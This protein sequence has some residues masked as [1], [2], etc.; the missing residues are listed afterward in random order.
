MGN[1]FMT[2][3]EFFGGADNGK[4]NS[5]RAPRKRG[6][7]AEEDLFASV[8]TKMV[9]R[10]FGVSRARALEIIA[11]KDGEQAAAETDEAVADETD[12]DGV[13]MTAREF[14]GAGED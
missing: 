10:V 3:E 2:A 7:K 13:F 5:S 1:G 9:M 8:K 11:G 12:D 4:K 14:F 6:K